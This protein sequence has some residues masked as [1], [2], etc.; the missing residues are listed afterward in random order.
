MLRTCLNLNNFNLKFINCLK[1][2]K[3]GEVVFMIVVIAIWYI[4]LLLL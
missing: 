4:N 1:N 2:V 3:K